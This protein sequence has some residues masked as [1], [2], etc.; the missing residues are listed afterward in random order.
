METVKV[1]DEIFPLTHPLNIH[2]KLYRTNKN[3][4]RKFLHMKAAHDLLWPHE[5][6]SWN[7]WTERRFRTH[8]EGYNYITYAGGANTTKSYDAAKIGLIFYLANPEERGVIVASTTLSGLDARVWGY[9]KK[10]LKEVAIRL[11]VTYTGS[12][13]PKVLYNTKKTQGFDNIKDSIHGMFAIAAKKG[14]DESAIAG[15]IGRHPTDMIL[16]IL[17][18]A[19]DMPLSIIK[20]FPNLEAKPDKFQCMAIGNSLSRYDLHGS[21]STPKNGWQSVNPMQDTS[22]LTT[23]RNGICLFFSCYDSP[24]IHESDPIKKQLLSTFLITEEELKGKE[25]DLGKE[26]ESF[27]RFVLGFWKSSSSSE[28]VISIDFIERYKVKDLAE[29][30]GM[31]PLRVVLGLDPAFTNGGDGCVLR[32]GMLGVDMTGRMV[33]DYRGDKFLFRLNI[34]ANIA[35]SV[36]LQIADQVIDLATEMGVPL[37]DIFI[38]ANGRGWGLAET[39]RLRYSARIGRNYTGISKKVITSRLGHGLTN[40]EEEGCVIRNAYDLWFNFRG[41]IENEQI[42]GMD[43]SSIIQLTN[44]LVVVEEGKSSNRKPK[45]EDKKLYKRRMGTIMKAMAKSPDEMDAASLTLLCAQVNYGFHI[46]QTFNIETSPMMQKI[47]FAH[48]AAQMQVQSHDV[49]DASFTPG[50]VKKKPLTMNFTASVESYA[51]KKLI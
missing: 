46:G 43:N 22:W 30:S 40:P 7:Y 19:T 47:Y 9:V 13:N 28:T 17:D 42:K 41:F 45:L 12:P 26:S 6:P 37:E 51:N 5:I 35:K 2:L 49:R 14:D 4:E 16:L 11:P 29:W 48:R 50:A 27:Y 20:S 23:Q 39:I 18:E 8:C 33:L 31:Y 38:D 24:A 44:R 32:G 1:E 34:I 25:I 10:F 15:W 21:L 36:D 3:P